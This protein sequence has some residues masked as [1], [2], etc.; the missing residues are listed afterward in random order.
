MG[1][2]GQSISCAG[3]KTLV[4]IP[5]FQVKLDVTVNIWNPSA[6]LQRWRAE[7]REVLKEHLDSHL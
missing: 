5:K 7:T 1:L 4:Q 2:S 3:M 6:P